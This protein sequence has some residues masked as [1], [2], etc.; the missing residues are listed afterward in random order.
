[1]NISTLLNDFRGQMSWGRFCALV[2]LVQAIC[3]Q[4]QGG[5][6]ESLMIWL[7]AALGN[8]GAA[9]LPEMLQ[10]SPKP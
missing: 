6:A 10:S 9:K 1:M 2:C 5:S 8:Y 3:I 7:G 4:Y